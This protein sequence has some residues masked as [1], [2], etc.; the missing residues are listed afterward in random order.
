[1]RWV[2][3][4]L[5]L[6]ILVPAAPNKPSLPN[7]LL[8][9]YPAAILMLLGAA[10]LLAAA[11][12]IQQVN[13]LTPLHRPRPDAGL[14]THGLYAILRHPIYA[15][16]L[17][18]GLGTALFVGGWLNL[19]AWV[20]LAI[21][22]NLKANDEEHLLKQNHPAYKSY[23]TTVPKFFPRIPV[24]LRTDARL[25]AL[26]VICALVPL[27]HCFAVDRVTVRTCQEADE[28][29]PPAKRVPVFLA[30]SAFDGYMWNRLALD[31]GTDG[32]WR[33]RRTNFDNPPEGREVHWNTSFAWALR[34]F[35]E[36]WRS[37]SGETL[38]QAIF[39][40]SIWV[41]SLLLVGAIVAVTVLLPERLG[42]LRGAVVAVGMTFCPPFY[43]AF[44]PAAPDHHGAVLL[45]VLGMLL[46]LAGSGAGWTCL[47]KNSC[48]PT[49]LSEAQVAMR[50]SAIFGAAGLWIN[51]FSILPLIGGA[52]LGALCAAAVGRGCR[53]ESL[54][55]NPSLWRLWGR[56]GC[57]TA[58]GFYCLEKLPDALSLRLEVNH[59]FHA[60]AWLGAGELLA[61]I[62]GRVTNPSHSLRFVETAAALIA[63]VC[64]GVCI[65]FLGERVYL[66]LDPFLKAVHDHIAEFRP[67]IERLQLGL[68]DY[69]TT[70]GFLPAFP[71]GA[72]VVVLAGKMAAPIRIAAAGLL[73]CGMLALIMPFVQMRWILVL[74]AVSVALA[75]ALIPELFRL[76]FRRQGW[77]WFVG[78]FVVALFLLVYGVSLLSKQLAPALRQYFRASHDTITPLQKMALVHRELAAQI[79]TNEPTTSSPIVLAGPSSAVMLASLGN[80]RTVGTFYWEN[81]EGLAKCARLMTATNRRRIVSDL[82]DLGITH[83][84]ILDWENFSE[85]FHHI[86]EHG[87][88]EM[89]RKARRKSLWHGV[90]AG[91]APPPA[92]E[93]LAIVPRRLKEELRQRGVVLRVK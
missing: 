78:R 81:R 64:P 17:I 71:L 60:L 68:A 54:R 12:Q 37:L 26:G 36:C 82:T 25:I 93:T 6:F 15:G 57:A 13:A 16:V 83:V 66:P 21:L 86:F 22:L 11:V 41:N 31:L 80:F 52:C 23:A 72:L 74:G 29:I 19:V 58:L 2:L 92:L 28:T 14:T 5:I 50:T 70:L 88:P 1:M 84:V 8:L 30:Q 7:G 27:V 45:C 89:A 46:G 18:L 33:L 32:S 39:R 24:S 69:W 49:T 65:L 43:E 55:Y 10:T 79:S 48:L 67:L 35:G 34:V 4:Q 53:E 63:L 85:E 76:A 91:E 59:P 62:C 42:R 56:W 90:L 51:A 47:E 44:L 3:L 40:A 9:K 61:A 87:A 73:P 20:L 38:Q 75:A 77:D